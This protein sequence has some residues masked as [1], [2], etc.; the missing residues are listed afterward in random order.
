MQR[1]NLQTAKQMM[2][3]K[4]SVEVGLS[5]DVKEIFDIEMIDDLREM[6]Q[7]SILKVD[8]MQQ[9]NSNFAAQYPAKWSFYGCMKGMS[10][11]NGDTL[12]SHAKAWTA[13]DCGDWIRVFGEII[14]AKSFFS[15]N[16]EA[17]RTAP[18]LGGEKGYWS[19]P[20]APQAAKGQTSGDQALHQANLQPSALRRRLEYNTLTIHDQGLYGLETTESGFLMKSMM[21]S[22][23]KKW[24]IMAEDVTGKMDRIFGLM[25]GATISGTTTDNIYFLNKFGKAIKDPIL[26]LLPVGSIAGGGHHSLIE[27]AIPLTINS[28]IDYSVGLYSTLIPGGMVPG[29]SAKRSMGAEAL[30]K[31]CGLWEARPENHLLLC[32]Y[33]QGQLAGALV[34]DKIKDRAS[35]LRAFK[36][37]ASLMEAFAEMAISPTEG[38][39]LNFMRLRGIRWN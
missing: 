27:V 21:A 31:V 9:N 33:E 1:V 22:G 8:K 18:Q 5:L 35:W 11:W 37:D 7:A 39:L 3:E 15:L 23:I 25:K 12:L 28:F 32:F 20:R 14:E 36:A 34:A 13:S 6:C 16:Q 4:Q 10:A 26:Y 24:A 19:K 2:V 30:R 17:K 38:Q 29:R